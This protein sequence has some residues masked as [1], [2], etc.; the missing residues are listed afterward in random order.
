MA[1]LYE[2]DILLWSERQAQLL[3][4]HADAVRTNDPIDWPNI[5]EEIE[6]VGRSERTALASHI[7][8]I[9]EHLA[10]LEAS[11]A[12]APRAGWCETIARARARADVA[13][14]LEDSPSLAPS[15]PAVCA[16]QRQRVGPIVAASLAAYGETPRVPLEHLS[17]TMEQVLGPWLPAT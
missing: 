15:L 6:S 12:V 11:T 1:N 10:R 8:I 4:Q 14:L 2:D 5:I 7:R 17:Y 3:R 13:D 9:L 16:R